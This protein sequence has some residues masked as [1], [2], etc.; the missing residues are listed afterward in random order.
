MALHNCLCVYSQSA[1]M[2][3]TPDSSV[4]HVYNGQTLSSSYVNGLH[5]CGI[6]SWV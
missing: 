3:H 4:L 1:W 6:H 5:H 2:M